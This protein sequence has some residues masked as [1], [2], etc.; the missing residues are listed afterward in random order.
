MYDN[1]D[2]DSSKY[3]DKLFPFLVQR[4]QISKVVKK[5]STRNIYKN[6]QNPQTPYPF[7]C[8]KNHRILKLII[9]F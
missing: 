8:I 5:Y 7:V 4:P 9:V 2:D 3:V 6:K 1:N